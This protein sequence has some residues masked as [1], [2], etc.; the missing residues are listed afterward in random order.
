MSTETAFIIHSGNYNEKTD[1]NND[2]LVRFI[3]DDLLDFEPA[4]SSCTLTDI[5]KLAD[6]LS[7]K[8]RYANQ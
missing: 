8:E 2:V 5:L 1:G 7:G 4:L 6:Q 3:D